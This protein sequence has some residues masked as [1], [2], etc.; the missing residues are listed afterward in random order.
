LP[1]IKIEQVTVAPRSE[2]LGFV[3]Y[4]DEDFITTATKDEIFKNLCVLMAGRVVKV[5][6]F[7]VKGMD[8]GDVADIGQATLEAYAAIAHLGMDEDLG[9]INILALNESVASGFLKEKIEHR[10][11]AWLNE[12]KVDTETLV[13]KYWD[14]VDLVAQKLIVKE[15]LSG[16]ELNKIV[17]EF[18]LHT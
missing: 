4:K 8:S 16:E 13:E 10:V 14:I 7:G 6:K 15:M 5:K 12:A 11:L 1:N 9:Y 18:K 2:V 3:S 17:Q